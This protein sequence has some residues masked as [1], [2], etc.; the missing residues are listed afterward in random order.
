MNEPM[1]FDNRLDRIMFLAE[2]K[3]C[4]QPPITYANPNEIPINL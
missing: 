1:E 2:N 4:T 3:L